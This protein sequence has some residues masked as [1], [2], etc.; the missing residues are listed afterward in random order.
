MK[1]VQ[2]I[3]N[4]CFNSQAESHRQS[5]QC[6]AEQQ[7]LGA[8]AI[9]LRCTMENIFVLLELIAD[10]DPFLKKHTDKHGNKGRSKP[11][12]EREGELFSLKGKKTTQAI[13][14]EI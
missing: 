8:T 4:T 7:F 2:N 12:A 11:S 6:W 5:E 10:F 9:L 3:D 13:A 1:G 14:K